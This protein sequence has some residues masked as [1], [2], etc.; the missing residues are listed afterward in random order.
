MEKTQLCDGIRNCR[1][2][3]DEEGCDNNNNYCDLNNGGCDQICVEA[4]NSAICKCQQGYKLSGIS[5]CIGNFHFIITKHF[6]LFCSDINECESPSTCPQLCSNSEGNYTCSCAK[7]YIQS[8]SDMNSCKI[9][10]GKLL[11]IYTHQVL[12]QVNGN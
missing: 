10:K 9:S 3:E 2:G 6:H 8:K 5:S 11:L 1:N 7:G 12:S 4:Q